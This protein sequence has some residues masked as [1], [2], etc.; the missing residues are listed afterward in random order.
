MESYFVLLIYY[1][2]VYGSCHLCF[3]NNGR[4][5]VLLEIRSVDF[6]ALAAVIGRCSN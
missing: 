3:V 5:V 6:R 4:L 2:G 1:L